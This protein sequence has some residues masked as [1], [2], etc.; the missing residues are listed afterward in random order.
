[1][2]ENLIFKPV[3][4]DEITL[5]CFMGEAVC[6]IQ[7]LESAISCSITIKKHSTAT[8]AEADKALSKQHMYYTLGKA[9]RLAEKEKLFSWPLQT[10][11]NDF[12]Q[13][14]NWLV[15]QAM[16]DNR[17]DL[18]S[19]RPCLYINAVFGKEYFMLRPLYSYS[20]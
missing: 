19:D 5:Y 11:L 12:Y 9:A 17:D 18:S 4:Q 7:A 8:K 2:K 16:F 10:D 20:L 6:K 14:R 15:H 13:R 1:M 3:N